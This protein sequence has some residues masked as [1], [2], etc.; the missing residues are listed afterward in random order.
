MNE[1]F[2]LRSGPILGCRGREVGPGQG[3][4]T[5]PTEVN[6][7]SD[8]GISRRTVNKVDDQG[9]NSTTGRSTPRVLDTDNGHGFRLDLCLKRQTQGCLGFDF[10]SKPEVRCTTRVLV[11]STEKVG[12]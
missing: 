5:A 8:R 10:S 9:Q 6:R 3:G 12:D 1:S 7:S 4:R 11:F 2:C